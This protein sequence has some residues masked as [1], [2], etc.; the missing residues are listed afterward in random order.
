MNSSSTF[1]Q[2]TLSSING[3]CNAFDIGMPHSCNK[4]E[5]VTNEFPEYTIG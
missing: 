5:T 2:I 3:I 4:S 1:L